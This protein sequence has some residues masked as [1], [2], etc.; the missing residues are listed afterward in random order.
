MMGTPIE[1]IKRLREESHA[2]VQDCRKAMEQTNSNYEKALEYLREKELVSMAKRADQAA[3]NGMLEVYSHGNGRI[4]VMVE[5]N[6]ETDFAGRSA[7]FK[8]FAHEI[9]L[10]I[11]AAAP[12]YI[13][14]DDIPAEVMRAEY[15]EKAS[16]VRNAG[17]PESIIP[18]IVEGYL[19]KFKDEHVLLRQRYIRDDKITIAQLLRQTMASVGENIVIRRF[20]RWELGDSAT[21]V[22][23]P[24]IVAIG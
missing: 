9:A 19:G 14:E 21:N 4:G 6:T 22:E 3:T 10:Q 20:V 18:K 8:S 12:D 17:K 16:Q 11:V 13:C 7:I 23:D 2:G 24:V 15:E 1:L 5:I